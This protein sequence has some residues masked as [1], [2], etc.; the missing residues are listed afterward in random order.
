MNVTALV[1]T[2]LV[3]ILGVFDLCAVVVGYVR[4]KDVSY[5]VSRFMQMLPIKA[6]F[7]VCVCFYVMGHFWGFMNCPACPSC[8]TAII[9]E[10][11]PTPI[12]QPGLERK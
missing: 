7:F 11:E 8:P 6:P 5:S 1:V 12:N 10:I 4:G 2:T 9:E 3:I